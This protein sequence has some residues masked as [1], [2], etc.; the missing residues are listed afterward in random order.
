MRTLAGV[1]LWT[2]KLDSPNGGSV[3]VQLI[4]SLP[5]YIKR[6]LL[7]VCFAVTSHIIPGASPG[8]SKQYFCLEH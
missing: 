2:A 4:I 3:Q 1:C 8:R 6:L 5:L 7:A